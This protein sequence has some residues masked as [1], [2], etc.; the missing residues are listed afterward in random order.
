VTKESAIFAKVLAG[1][2]AGFFPLPAEVLA[3]RRADA[4][5]NAALGEINTQ[6]RAANPAAVRTRIAAEVIELAR[7]GD[8]PG[9]YE[10]EF[11]AEQ[12]KLAR[13]SAAQSILAEARRD[14]IDKAPWEAMRL[15]EAILKDYLRPALNT[16]LDGVR[17]GVG[18][19]TAIPWG[20]QSALLRAREEV[21]EYYDLLTTAADHYAAIRDAQGRLHD[22]TGHP[23]KEA[24]HRFAELRNMRD[25][26]PQRDSGAQSIRG[27][28]PWPDDRIERMVWLVTSAAEPWLPTAVECEAA[29]DDLIAN[30][31][32]LGGIVVGDRD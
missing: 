25:V 24:F 3:D 23:S 15:S 22:L 27:H 31:R 29:N 11:V 16:V 13:L 28:A 20:N 32:T 18:L 12:E 9:G 30:S 1:H 10:L 8:L 6:L 4:V 7:T 14:L 19:A 26:W 21:R 17:S 5:L 2:D